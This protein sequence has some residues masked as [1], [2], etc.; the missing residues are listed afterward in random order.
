MASPGVYSGTW[1]V[2]HGLMSFS[3]LFQ[4]TGYMETPLSYS[5][6]EDLQLLSWDNA[7]KYCVQLS[8]PG[9]TVLLQVT[10]M[11]HSHLRSIWWVRVPHVLISSV[12]VEPWLLVLIQCSLLSGL[13]AA[14][15][16]DTMSSCAQR[17]TAG[18][19]VI[20]SDGLWCSL[21][22]V[23][24]GEHIQ[25]QLACLPACELCNSTFTTRRF[26]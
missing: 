19:G 13:L 9:G 21:W 11:S 16:S 17:G 12:S 14:C 7:P 23:E 26:G 25:L 2:P 15:L 8:V 4:P 10:Q 1:T 3:L 22:E 20:G 18:H 24:P 6:I 5:T